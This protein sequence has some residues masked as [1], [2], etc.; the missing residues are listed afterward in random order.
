[1]ALPITVAGVMSG[2][3]L[4]GLDIAVCRFEALSGRWAFDVLATKTI[5]YTEEWRNRLSM[6]FTATG[7][8]LAHLHA[9]F[10]NYIGTCVKQF[11]EE[12]SLRPDYV[13]S[14]GHTIFH[15]PDKGLTLQIGCGAH[16]ASVTG[17]DTVCDFRT[18]DVAMGG[19]GA[20]LV[21]VGDQ[22]LFGGHRFCLNLGGIAN[23]SFDKNEQRVAYD[24]CPANMVLNYLAQQAG[25]SFDKDGEL[26][27]EG[28]II[29]ELLDQLNALSFY[30]KSPPK[31][32][33]REWFETEF[34][35]AIENDSYSIPD[36]LRTVIEHI[37]IQ[38]ANALFLSP[39]TTMLTTGGGAY[40]N[41]LIEVIEEQIS[42]HGIHVVVPDATIVE[43]KEAIIFAFLGV[44]RVNNLA[45][46]LASVTGAKKDSIGGAI[47]KA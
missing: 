22:I 28:T 43:F 3:S 40:H 6:A 4:D 20:P 38:V 16:I 32:L 27:G 41:L 42:R 19:Q 26:S 44:L 9:D 29:P 5:P 37:G 15:Q 39:G 35:P 25:R 33:G 34:L 24:I 14:H 13:S 45:N 21:P 11:C 31:S 30:R 7:H 12:Q 23:I 46:A 1:M 2:T 17:F 8:E 18:T 10:G 36:R 47:Y